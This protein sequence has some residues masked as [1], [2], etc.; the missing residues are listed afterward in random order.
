MNKLLLDAA[1][2]GFRD[3]VRLAITILAT[4]ANAVMDFIIDPE[5]RDKPAR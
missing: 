5:R 1:A 4:V 2:E 3:S